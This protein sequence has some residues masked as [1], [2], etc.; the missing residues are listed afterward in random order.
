MEIPKKLPQ[1][2]SLSAE[3]RY[4]VRIYWRGK[5]HSIGNFWTLGDAKAAS[6]IARSEMARGIF[7]PPSELRRERASQD[8]LDLIEATTVA[9]WG[10]EWLAR[11]EGVG[12]TPATIRSYRSTLHAH[13]VPAIGH[14]RLAE[15]TT[16]DIDTMLNTLKA[17]PGA[18]T[19]VA[20]VTRSLF[21]AAI[22]AGAGG[23][24]VSPF[25]AHIES[26]RKRRERGLDRSD[27]ATPAEVRAMSDAMPAELRVAVMLGAWCAMRQG[28]VLG[29]QRRDFRHL[30]DP[31][32]A[33]VRIDRQWNAKATPPTYT[34]PKAGSARELSIPAALVPMIRDHLERFTPAADDAPILPRRGRPHLPISQSAFDLAWRKAR[35]TVRPGFRFHSLRHT[36][37]TEYART[38]AT[39]AELK[40]RGGHSSADVAMRYQHSSI[41]RDRANVARM[42]VMVGEGDRHE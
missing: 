9:Q 24:T 18:W 14:M 23:I 25:A 22:S 31:D 37:L 21:L 2:I 41:D 42:N 20:R 35:E 34:P 28:E 39:L 3:G 33:T 7:I 11:L 40:E 5:Q 36:G 16:A 26:T 10:A 4:R 19:N 38:G 6:A 8:V 13:I 30:D 12:R 32:N 29:L 17:S 27:L 15:V 1:G